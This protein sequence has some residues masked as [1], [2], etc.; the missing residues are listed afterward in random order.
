[1]KV[2][3]ASTARRWYLFLGGAAVGGILSWI[4]F[5]YI[6]GVF[7]EEQTALI[8][9]QKIEIKELTNDLHILTEDRNKLNNENKKLLTIQEIKVEI[10]NPEKFDLDSLTVESLTTSLQ[11]DLRHLLTKHVHSVAKNKELLKKAIE[12]KVYNL[13]DRTYQFEVDTIYF[14]TTLEISVKITQKR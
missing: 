14:D 13:Y 3:T 6:Y 5:L 11:D 2:P 4:I 7:Q 9:T 12:H 1:M 8:E 10:T